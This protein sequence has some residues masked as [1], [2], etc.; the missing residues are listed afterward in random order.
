[1]KVQIILLG[2]VIT[3]LGVVAIQT[4]PTVSAQSPTRTATEE[5]GRL[6][7]WD[8]ILSGNRD[9]ACATCHH[10]E[11]AYADGRAL[12]LGVGSVGLGPARTDTT[13]G[14]I[15]V[16]KRNAHTILNVGFN[17]LDDNRRRREAFD[18]TVAS[19]NQENAPMFWDNRMRSLELQAL[20]PIKSLE[21]MRGRAYP[22]DEALDRVVARLEAIPEYVAL[23]GRAF[24]PEASVTSLRLGE[25]IAA[26]E[27]TLI[28]MNSPFDRFRGGDRDA[29]SEEQ[30]RGME[31][32][33]DAGCDR[34]H[35]GV[36]F[37]DFDLHAEGV[38]EHP[39]LESADAGATAGS[40]SGR[41]R[42]ATLPLRRHTC[43]TAH[44][45]LLRMCCAFMTMAVPKTRTYPTPAGGDSETA[46]P[47]SLAASAA[48]TTW[49]DER[50]PASSPFSER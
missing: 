24:G 26:F 37:S 19:V 2:F 28:A 30:R 18:G 46:C 6:L 31:E 39:L 9:I 1:M 44:W 43:I 7:F 50:W 3:I 36:M 40:V 15:P 34:C 38:A 10:P 41:R 33:D 29:L 23:F 13:G 16:V 5:L 47:A 48:W 14:V 4:A 35:D 42:S 27:R 20:E 11:F 21:E 17:G 22:E 45:R 49:T 12:S 25:A 32:F 8:P